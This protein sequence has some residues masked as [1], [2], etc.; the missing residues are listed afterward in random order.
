MECLN[1]GEA[2][3]LRALIR[4]GKFKWQQQD[5]SGEDLRSKILPGLRHIRFDCL[6]Q[7]EFVE[8]CKEELGEVLTAA[9]KFSIAMSIFTGDWKMM[10]TDIVS[11]SKLMSRHEPYTFISLP[12]EEDSSERLSGISGETDINFTVNKKAT[13]VGVKLITKYAHPSLRAITLSNSHNNTW[14]VIGTGHSN[15]TSLNRGEMFHKINSTQSLAEG[16]WYRLTFSFAPTAE[17][18]RVYT[19]PED[20]N[21]RHSVGLGVKII[22][23]HQKCLVNIVGLVFLK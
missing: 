3:L 19:L 13:L 16:T 22:D 8:L 17:Q 6:T 2:D 12:Y 7:Y 21:P 5:K 15:V 10:P 14:T 18:L 20:K 4:W 11:H 9:E 23:V 1:I